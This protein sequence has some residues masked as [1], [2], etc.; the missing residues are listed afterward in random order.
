MSGLS[1]FRHVDRRWQPVWAD[2]DGRSTLIAQVVLVELLSNGE[3]AA[4]DQL[5]TTL[6]S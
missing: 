2:R 6:D 3:V 4:E 5:L 1:P